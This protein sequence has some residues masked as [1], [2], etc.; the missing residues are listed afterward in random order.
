MRVKY[1]KTIKGLGMLVMLCLI[2]RVVIIDVTQ[3][4]LK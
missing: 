1:Y 3:S 4:W 2:D